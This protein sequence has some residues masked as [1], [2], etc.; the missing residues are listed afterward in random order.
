MVDIMRLAKLTNLLLCLLLQSNS[1]D[2][3]WFAP[4]VEDTILLHLIFWR[5]A[6]I[7]GR[8]HLTFGRWIRKPLY[9]LVLLRKEGV[10][11]PSGQLEGMLPE[12]GCVWKQ[13]AAKMPYKRVFPCLWHLMHSVFAEFKKHVGLKWTWHVNRFSTVN[14]SPM[15]RIRL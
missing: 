10:W 4:R 11:L 12:K 1:S 9:R 2:H 6:R 7:L 14:T 8:L 15:F 13:T 3:Y 5:K